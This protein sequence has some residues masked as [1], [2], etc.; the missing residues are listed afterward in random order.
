MPRLRTYREVFEEERA[1][2]EE[3]EPG[4]EPVIPQPKVPE[5]LP[6]PKPEPPLKPP[7]TTLEPVIPQPY[8]PPVD[9]KVVARDAKG[10]PT[11]L[12]TPD[13]ER[14][15]TPAQTIM[16]GNY[17]FATEA[18]YVEAQKTGFASPYIGISRGVEAPVRVSRTAMIEAGKLRG[19]EQ[20]NAYREAGVIP[21]GSKFVPGPEGYQGKIGATFTPTQSRK[22]KGR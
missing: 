13:G 12:Q 9:A 10:E 5:R 19:E 21:Y 14:H 4:L 22:L 16:W 18:E 6:P 2:R 15:Y 11:V 1:K 3:R 17:G 8:V 7:P 20:F